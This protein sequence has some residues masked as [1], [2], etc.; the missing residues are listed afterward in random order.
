MTHQRYTGNRGGTIMAQRP[1][2]PNMRARVAHYLTPVENLLLGGHWAEYGGGVP[3]A[4]RAG[5][6]SALIILKQERPP[7]FEVVRDVID[8]KLDPS[9]VRS[10]ALK[11]LDEAPP[12]SVPR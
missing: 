10:P 7:A 6:N 11:T 3:V 12:A 1:T 8:G 2:R 5:M 9:E 4:V